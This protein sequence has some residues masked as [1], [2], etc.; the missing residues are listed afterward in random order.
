LQSSYYLS[1][2]KDSLLSAHNAV[3]MIE[4]NDEAGKVIGKG[5]YGDTTYKIDRAAEEA[6]EKVAREHFS[7]PCIISEEA[8]I[9]K[10]DEVYILLDPVDG[11]TNAK[12]GLGPF[13][14]AIAV[15]ESIEFAGIVAAGV[16]DHS[17][18]RMVWGDSKRV[19]ED[20]KIAK[21]G[22]VESIRDAII[23]FDSKFYMLNQDKIEKVTRLMKETL[24]PRVF[25]TAALETAYISSGRIDAYVCSGGRLRSFDCF[26]SLFLLR[27]SGCPFSL[28]RIE[29]LRLDTKDTF[30]YF[31]ACNKSLYE[32][33]EKR[34]E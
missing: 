22:K 21:P 5:A 10:G 32:E 34:L 23:S 20:W 11:S 1:F 18:S 14:T 4:K 24:Y 27:T 26:P 15:S 25:S 30:A 28:E 8:G 2:I 13:S 19:Y 33:I 16:I 12:R 6:V 7:N 3:M 29:E 31:A 9:S 17:T